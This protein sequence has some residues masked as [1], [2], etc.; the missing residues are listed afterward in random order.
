M[1]NRMFLLSSICLCLFS[2]SAL[3][4]SEND[5]DLFSKDISPLHKAVEREDLKKVQAL[6]DQG[7]YIDQRLPEECR[8]D[9]EWWVCIEGSTPLEIALKKRNL[10]IVQLLLDRGA[11]PFNLKK[12]TNTDTA[13]HSPTT[14][15]TYTS[16]MYELIDNYW[17]NQ[18]NQRADLNLFNI[19]VLKHLIKLGVDLNNVCLIYHNGVSYIPLPYTRSIKS[20]YIE[21]LKKT[22][23][24]KKMI[25][26]LE[27][28]ENLLIEGGARQ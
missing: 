26:A 25:E 8:M 17:M 14:S 5:D 18:F 27:K 22:K 28:L 15:S 19:K 12:E 1:L 24:D 20:Y 13:G 16:M 10:P 23:E 11:N 6:L 2:I 7:Y 21:K 4:S 3:F 9:E